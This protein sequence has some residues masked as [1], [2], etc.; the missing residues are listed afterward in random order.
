MGRARTDGR[1]EGRDDGRVGMYQHA[2]QDVG[3]PVLLAATLD[4]VECVQRQD[5]AVLPVGLG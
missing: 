1:G 3:Q 4:F 2:V 5:G